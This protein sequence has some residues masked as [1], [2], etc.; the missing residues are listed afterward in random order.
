VSEVAISVEGFVANDLTVRQ[1]GSSRVVDVSVP[2]T[3]RRKNRDTGEWEDSGETVWFEA[4][5]WDGHADSV[6]DSVQKGSLVS[7]TGSVKL[8][9]YLKRDGTPGAKAVV[10]SPTIAVIVRRPSRSTP[11]GS[12]SY[13]APTAP[14]GGDDAEQWSAG[15]AGT[16]F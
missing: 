16:P 4:S 12:S 8:E 6:L 9:A 3:P 5:F 7:L 2:H 13:Q 15:D 10:T 11:N 14:S 1:A